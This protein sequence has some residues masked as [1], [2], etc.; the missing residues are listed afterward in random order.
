MI[1]RMR[2][3]ILAETSSVDVVSV[4][5]WSAVLMALLIAGMAFALRLKRRIKA[6]DSEPVPVA[7]FTLSDLRQM[8][9][10]GQISDAEFAKAKEK[11]VAA[12]KKAAERELD[13][14]DPVERDSADAI[15]ARRLS[16]E[17]MEQDQFGAEDDGPPPHGNR[18]VQ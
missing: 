9:R 18:P 10:A 13:P 4:I 5:L 16:R 6:E 12:A 2:M 17:A 15:R 8:H 14:A 1:A 3:V 7:G 11:V